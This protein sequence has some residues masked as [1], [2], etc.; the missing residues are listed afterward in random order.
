MLI[1]QA[2][3]EADGT[4]GSQLRNMGPIYKAKKA[5]ADRAQSELDETI[6][7]IT[8][9][10]DANNLAIAT[11]QTQMTDEL[12]AIE[13]T[14]YD[15]MAARIEALDRLSAKS[16]AISMAHLFILLLFIIIESAPVL[17][18]LIS[19]RS[20]YDFVLHKHEHEF[21]MYHKE[22]TALLAN[23]THAKV[24][25][26][27]EISSAQVRARIKEERAKIES[28]LKNRIEGFGESRT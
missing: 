26:D 11:I 22:K 17:V 6:A 3:E 16:A 9:Q 2:I 12:S 8:P 28:D 24:T 4:G 23:A 5:E 1:Q 27:T 20:P 15:G 10:L 19:F 13:R 18:K 21:E 25:Y 14:P 7:A